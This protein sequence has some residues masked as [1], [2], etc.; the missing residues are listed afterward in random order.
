M[1]DVAAQAGVSQATV[2]LVLNGNPGARFSADTRSRVKRAAEDLGY[3]LVRRGK[4]VAPLDQTVIGFIADEVT[5]D[6]WMALAFDGAREK[7][8]EYG[9]SA[10][11]AI[12]PGDPE[13]DTF[14]VD[15]M[16]Q[17]PLLGMVFG[18]ILTRRIKPTAAMLEQPTV[19]LNC[20]DAERRL[21][22]VLPGDVVGGRVAT[23][24]LILAGRRRIGMING[25]PGLDASRDRLR[26]YRQALASHD[27]PFDPE[28]VR[29]GN[30]EPS[31]GY[32]MTRELMSLS[33]PPDAIFC[34]NDMMAMGCYDALRELGL[35]IPED[36][37]VVG[38]DDREIAQFMRPPL[39]T[40]LLP[41]REM[42][43]IAAEML[44]EKARGSAARPTQIKVECQVVP[45]QSVAFG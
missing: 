33:G 39:T 45:R 6:P 22:S 2:S 8:L 44:I 23:E 14:V 17:K 11:M 36:V 35:R 21:P 34:A 32:E 31:A 43:A 12:T 9:M 29:P 10:C 24:Q 1:M 7:A 20:Y 42:G 5:T 26:G 16:R 41:F 28:L 37:A 40:L 18:T 4:R 19:L 15:Q 3:Q 25:Q 30:W 38:F 13:A 27:I